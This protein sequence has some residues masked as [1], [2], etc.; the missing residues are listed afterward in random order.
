MTVGI[1]YCSNSVA[2]V[3]G[4]VGTVGIFYCSNSVQPVVGLVV[5]GLTVGIFIRHNNT[6]VVKSSR[7]ASALSP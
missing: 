6:P 2:P 3:V 4:M 7:S 1:F 5:T